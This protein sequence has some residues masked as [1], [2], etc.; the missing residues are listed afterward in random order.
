MTRVSEHEARVVFEA[1]TLNAD[2]DFLVDWNVGEDALAPVILTHRS[3]QPEGFFLLTLAPKP[4][5][6]PR[7]AEMFMQVDMDARASRGQC[8]HPRHAHFDRRSRVRSEK[9]RLEG[10]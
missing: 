1:K 3:H 9:H 2:R 4:G 6:K 7:A 5:K 8:Y 10:T